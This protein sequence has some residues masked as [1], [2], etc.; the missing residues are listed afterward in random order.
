M[1]TR[2]HCAFPL[3]AFGVALL[4][5]GCGIDPSTDGPASSSLTST[6]GTFGKTTIG[7]QSGAMGAGI[8]RVV[9][10][11]LGEAGNATSLSAYLR[12]DGTANTQELRAVIYSDVGG[13]PAALLA[14]S[15]ELAVHGSAVAGWRTLA[16]PGSVSLPA[17][18]YWIG[19]ITGGTGA[20]GYWDIATA[21]RCQENDA[22]ADGPMSRFGSCVPT[23]YQ[24]SFY[25]TYTP[26]GASDAGVS[27]AQPGPD[28]GTGSDAS[29]GTDAAS[30]DASVSPPD[31]SASAWGP[32]VAMT[33]SGSSIADTAIAASGTTLHYVYSTGWG[34]ANIEY[35]RSTDEGATW[36]AP[37][38]IVRS[39]GLHFTD[40]I[41][42]NG[43]N[44]WVS[45]MENLSQYPV[46]WGM[47]EVGQLF[48]IH[49]GDGGFSWGTPV[50]ITTN[51][52]VF[53]YSIASTGSRID[54]SWSD[55]RAGA[56]QLFYRRSRDAGATWDTEVTLV[57]SAVGNNPVRPQLASFGNDIHVAWEEARSGRPG[58][59]NM[60]GGFCPDTWYKRSNDGGSTW[61]SDLQIIVGAGTGIPR[62]E[63]TVVPAT[64]AAELIFQNLPSGVTDPQVNQEIYARRTVDHGATWSAPYRITNAPGNSN[65]PT[66]SGR[67]N[68]VFT[69]WADQRSNPA[70]GDAASAVYF[71]VSTDGGATWLADEPVSMP[72]SAVADAIAGTTSYAHVAFVVTVGG[73]RQGFVRRR[74]I[75]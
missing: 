19:L 7:A 1:R 9:R 59:P 24:M 16:F 34:G 2:G 17:G 28:T 10:Y 23:D 51:A 57:S 5:S 37:V 38:T 35:R 72:A 25:V 36:S 18:A 65:H 27:D 8:T 62:P 40:A 58:C 22:C 54:L 61:S 66:A 3:V 53:R 29:A 67:G 41:T 49:S 55:F 43:S 20:V 52:R 73:V 60:W 13:Q 68:D 44:V 47:E 32:L 64:G 31:A 56:S 45:F 39:A 46:P 14:T 69:A 6:G 26:A 48:V 33:P 63:M 15:D 50:P 70:G 74:A 42:T 71:A 11:M 75:P 4:A 12:G 30:T 21:S